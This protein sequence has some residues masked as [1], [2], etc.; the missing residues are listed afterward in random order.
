[1]FA[2][3]WIVLL[4]L[5]MV[6]YHGWLDTPRTPGQ[7]PVSVLHADG[8][9]VV[10]LAPGARNHYYTRGRVNGHE[11]VL[12]VDTG[13][14]DMV[15]PHKLARQLQLPALGR[16]IAMTANG[17]VEVTRTRLDTL[18]IG[19]IRLFAVPAIITPGM[20]GEIILLGM[21]ALR[22]LDFRSEGGDLVLEQ[23]PRP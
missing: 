3:A 11:V 1:M 13:A 10:R 14:S 9:A 7:Q 21:S 2:L 5:G 20:E 15:V 8:T 19:E 17:R 16:G 22:E 4:G 12:L 18:E 6:A 23:A